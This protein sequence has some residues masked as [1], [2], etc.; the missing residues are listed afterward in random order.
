MVSKLSIIESVLLRLK[1]T[2]ILDHLDAE[3]FKALVLESFDLVHGPGDLVEAL[4]DL[5]LS[6][7]G[8]VGL[9]LSCALLVHQLV[10]VRQQALAL[11]WLSRSRRS[12]LSAEGVLALAVDHVLERLLD[13]DLLLGT[14]LV[15]LS[16][17]RARAHVVSTRRRRRSQ[18]PL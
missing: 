17:V 18:P 6:R 8:V 1:V 2:T 14:E 3:V 9:A 13:C 11:A 16:K 7:A 5:V 10:V 12:G 4:G 15:A